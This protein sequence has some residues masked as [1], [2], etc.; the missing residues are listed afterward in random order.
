M[1]VGWERWGVWEIPSPPG[2]L[3]YLHMALGPALSLLPCATWN[4]ATWARIP[5][6]E[7]GGRGSKGSPRV[8]S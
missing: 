6:R 2:A 7:G 5:R 8:L 1:G 4:P 3:S